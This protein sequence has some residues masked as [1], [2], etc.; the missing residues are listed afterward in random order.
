MRHYR[1]HAQIKNYFFD[2]SLPQRNDVEFIE[3]LGGGGTVLN[4]SPKCD[5]LHKKDELLLEKLIEKLFFII[6]GHP[7]DK[8]DLILLNS[9]V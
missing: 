8:R 2:P 3:N 1:P 5:R 6:K 9:R 7:K 4:F